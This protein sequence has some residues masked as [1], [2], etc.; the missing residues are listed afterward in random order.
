[1]T[2]QALDVV[3]S[4]GEHRPESGSACGCVSVKAMFSRGKLGALGILGAVFAANFFIS[5]LKKC[6]TEHKKDVKF[7]I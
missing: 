4:C 1:M 2:G 6:L 7:Y 5:S 3:I